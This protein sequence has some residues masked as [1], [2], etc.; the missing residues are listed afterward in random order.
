VPLNVNGNSCLCFNRDCTIVHART[1][2]VCCCYDCALLL[3]QNGGVCPTC[4][5]PIQMVVKY[6]FAQ[7]N[8]V[9]EVASPRNSAGRKSFT[10][11]DPRPFLNGDPTP[12][13]EKETSSLNNSKHSSVAN[14]PRTSD[15]T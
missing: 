1:G 3:K 2:H 10:F 15:S 12:P 9:L 13:R 5:A 14:T 8:E 11:E 4:K 7:Y 6:F